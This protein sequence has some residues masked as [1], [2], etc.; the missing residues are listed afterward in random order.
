MLTN[1]K[2]TL[3]GLCFLALA[4]VVL[5]A[6]NVEL[7]PKDAISVPRLINYQGKLTDGSGIPV[8]D[9]NYTVD[10]AV[11]AES[12]G[13]TSLWAE[14]QT[15]R[16]ANG[17][18]NVILGT[19]TPVVIP[20]GPNCFLQVTV[21]GALV[22]PRIR[23]ASTPYAYDAQAA[24]E[25]SHATAADVAVNAGHATRAD[26]A[27]SANTAGDADKLD[28]NHANAFT[29]LASDAGRSGVVTSLF[30][31]TSTLASKYAAIAHPHS[32]V[33]ITSGKVGNA[34]LNTGSGGGLDAD[35][36]D[37]SHASAFAAST[38]PHVGGD[39]T[40]G[41]ISDARLSPNV[42]LL[43][44]AQSFTAV[45]TFSS[46]PSFTASPPFAVSSGTAVTNLNADF[47]DGS[48]ATAFSSS[49]HN[50]D[51]MYIN[52][53]LGEVNAANDFNFTAPTQITNL[54]ADLLD[55]SHA[56][57]FATSAHTHTASGDVTGTVTGTLTIANDAV[58]SLKIANGTI[59]ATDIG[60]NA[61]S[62]DRIARGATSGQAIVA[63]GVAADATWDYPTA[64]GRSANSPTAVTFFR[65][66]R[67]S[68]DLPNIPV[69]ATDIVMNPAPAPLNN[70]AVN[71]YLFLSV[72]S[73]GGWANGLMLGAHC[74]VNAAG[75]FTVRVLNT[76]AGAINPAATNFEY[77]WLR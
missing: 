52:D 5:A 71:D 76:T 57:A 26:Q 10:F 30:E 32:G 56:T 40:S 28:G 2:K 9:G 11:F 3:S 48:H 33:D 65:F 14:R 44:S 42:A 17:L 51:A 37:G 60:A 67:V 68:I 7:N 39:I 19:T 27:D 34:Y 63:N 58:T 20:D 18:F 22:S 77:I 24:Q 50:H 25:A 12:A 36:L 23:M 74:F 45:K 54:G 46:A 64:L 41:T 70:L 75:Q 73:T 21:N 1:G 53:G 4:S 43:N 15:V 8:P 31:G 35:Q 29:T 38:H 6:G 16:A 61:V 13:G 55:G 49:S 66:G 72:N 59:A 69:G 62:L 47:L